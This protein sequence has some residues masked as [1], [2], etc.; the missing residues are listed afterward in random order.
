MI[1]RVEEGL[2][3]QFWRGDQ[4]SDNSK[5]PVLCTLMYWIYVKHLQFQLSKQLFHLIWQVR[6]SFG[7][8]LALGAINLG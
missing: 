4:K 8:R 2:G 1:G 6:L 7:V 3:A 5:G